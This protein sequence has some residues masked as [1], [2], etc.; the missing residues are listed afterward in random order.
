MA[1]VKAAHVAGVEDAGGPG[2]ARVPGGEKEGVGFVVFGGA[3]EG[4]GSEQEEEDRCF[5]ATVSTTC[6]EQ[7]VAKKLHPFSGMGA[8]ANN[9]QGPKS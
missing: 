5:Q 2:G 9:A 6:C 8:D 1:V 4:D 7:K 3:E